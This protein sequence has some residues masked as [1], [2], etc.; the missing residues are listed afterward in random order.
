MDWLI[1]L[2]KFKN[3]CQRS[4]K[5][6]KLSTDKKI[7]LEYNEI[8][9]SH[10]S[11]MYL[12]NCL[13][14]EFKANII[15]FLPSIP[16]NIL[17]IFY[18][19]LKKIFLS[20][21]FSFY[22]NFGCINFIIP[23]IINKKLSKKIFSKIYRTLKS[24]K[25]IYKIKIFGINFGDLI[26]DG[27][28]KCYDLP[29]IDI[30]A[31]SFKK[32]LIYFINYVIFWDNFLKNNKV[33]ALISSNT[34]YLHGVP[35][36][37]CVFKK[38]IRVYTTC[39]FFTYR[40]SKKKLSVFEMENYK[41]EFSKLSEDKK[42]KGIVQAKK[43]LDNKFSG[44]NTIENRMSLMPPK[45]SVEAKKST[46]RFLSKNNID[47]VLIAAHAFS[48][49]PNVFGR[50]FFNDFYDWINYLGKLSNKLIDREWYI[51]FHP[52]E[53]DVSL[54]HIDY[55]LK[56]YKNLNFIDKAATHPQLISEG[57]SLVLTVYGSVGYEF[58]YLGIPLINA[59]KYNPHISYNFN[60]HPKNLKDYEW[61][62]KN[63]KKLNL[64]YDKKNLYEY[65]FM[66]Y[67]NSFYLYHNE[68]KRKDKAR[69]NC[70][71]YEKWMNYCGKDRNIQL[72]KEMKKF[73]LS[74]KFKFTK[75]SI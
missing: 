59:S 10:I 52:V 19:N 39:N 1:V 13:K 74:D 72:M 66:R 33:V 73:I 3:F 64:N 26:Y 44:K 36:R 60:Y 54:K 25:D 14:E 65:F 2:T 69:H 37:M 45:S 31:E 34:V 30:H 32:Y 29:T 9:E 41:T 22:R 12:S 75:N 63:F 47:K 17:K 16:S 40:H 43:I 7:L 55:F 8:C 6:K 50:T 46:R 20:K 61:A 51:K 62:I 5:L 48:D 68:L 11:Y 71:A 70:E 4:F 58:A 38:N 42:S 18:I 57:I 15:G 27:Y 56:T 24:K 53:Q 49:A 28:L 23:R 21:Y 35:L 67:C